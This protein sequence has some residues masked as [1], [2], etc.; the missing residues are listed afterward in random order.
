MFLDEIDPFEAAVLSMVRM[1]RSK[2]VDYAQDEDRWSNFRHM[3]EFMGC[4]EDPWMS[5]LVLCQQKLS[6]IG[7]LRKNGRAPQ[8]EGVRDSILD[9]AVYA[10]IALAISKES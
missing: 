3:S 1:Y 10:A 4:P 2:R 5:A 9:N 6:R 7:A 8:N